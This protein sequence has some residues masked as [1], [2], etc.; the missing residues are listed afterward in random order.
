MI[1]NTFCA[2][3]TTGKAFIAEVNYNFIILIRIRNTL[4]I[5]GKK[6]GNKRIETKGLNTIQNISWLTS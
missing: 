3:S 5:P 4:L 2:V 1:L 6:L